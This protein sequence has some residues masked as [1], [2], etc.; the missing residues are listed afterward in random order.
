MS[1]FI[2]T[3]KYIPSAVQGFIRRIKGVMFLPLFEDGMYHAVVSR[4]V[5]SAVVIKILADFVEQSGGIHVSRETREEKLPVVAF[6]LAVK[7]FEGRNCL[8]MIIHDLNN[9]DTGAGGILQNLKR[10]CECSEL[11]CIACVA[12]ETL[13]RNQVHEC[14][15]A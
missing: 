6:G 1:E 10:L 12:C 11:S 3:T 13:L 5:S 14:R 2:P 9:S 7:W 4:E 8:F 15:Y